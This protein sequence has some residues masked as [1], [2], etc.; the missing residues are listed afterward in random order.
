MEVPS[1]L[2]N[3]VRDGR[4]V[5]FLGAGASKDSATADG[6][7]CPTTAEL[8]RLLSDKFLG[9][10][11]RD[12]Q[13][14]QIAEYAMSECGDLGRI[15]QFIREIFLA[16]Q[17]TNG[18]RLV[19]RFV[20]RGLVTTNYDL[21]IEDT[22]AQ[23]K[24]RLQETRPMIENK[25]RVDDNL[26]DARNVLLLKLHGCITRITSEMCPLILTPDQ[27]LEHRSGRSRLF[28]TLQEWGAEH[29]LVFV[30]HS[31]QD[32]DI[33]AVLLELRQLWEFRPR[34]Y[35]VAP[36]GDEIKARFFETKKITLLRGTFEE[37]FATLDAAIGVPFRSLASIR[38]PAGG[39]QIE[40]HF[41]AG[42]RLSDSTM[43][44]MNV[45]VEYVNGISALAQMDPK[46]FYKGYTGG[47]APLEQE[48]DVRRGI[49]DDITFEY[50]IRDQHEKTHGP[51]V[52]LIKA[53]AGAGKS[54]ILHRLAWDA[55]REYECICLFSK[56]Q[57]TL[58]AA[59]LQELV[60]SLRRRIYLFVDDAAD[61]S[62]ELESL[63]KRLGPE[64]DYLTILM[65]ERINEW[66]I[67]GQDA[68]PFITDEY[69]LKYLNAAE[70]DA[71]LALLERHHALGAHLE[72]LTLEER[73]KE[74]SEHAG[75]QLLVAL[76]EA[77]LGIPFE[78]ILVD[79]FNKITPFEAQRLYQTVCVLNRLNVPVRAGLV[80]RV[81]GIPFE[82]FEKRFFAPLEHV[83][84]AQR[85]ETTQDYHY[86]ARHPHIADVVFLKVLKTVEERFDCYIR[87][88][89]ALNVS[90]SVDWKAF[91]QM[92]RAR[93][94][95]DLFP[96]LQMVKAVFTA[97]RETVG[98]DAH[99][100]HQMGIYEMNRPDG[101]LA[102]AS[103]ALH[104]AEVLA[105]HDPSIR[106]SIAELKLKAD[107]RSRTPLEK[108]KLLREAAEIS[109]SLIHGEKTDSYA[110][111][112]LV[113]VEIRELEDGL[114]AGAPEAEIEALVKD[115]ESR[116]FDAQQE[117]PG[118]SHLLDAESRLAE[119][120]KDNARA[121]NA[122]SKA[123]DANPRN[124]IIAVR[125]ARQLERSGSTE[126]AADILRKALDANTNDSRLH[127]TYARL[128]MATT[129]EDGD[130]I[131]YHLRRA[132]KDGDDSFEAQLLYGRQLFL[133]GN[134]DESRSLFRRL[135]A[136]RVAPEI[137]NRLLHPIRGRRFEGRMSRPQG[138]YAFI[139]R[140]GPS[141]QIYVHATNVPVDTWEVLTMGMR[142]RFSIAFSLC[143]VNAFDLETV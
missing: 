26:R 126:K 31:V 95:L 33:R 47:F 19:P 48:L 97:A 81:H 74:L 110:H 7:R 132:F 1:D 89:K 100:L 129:P 3:Q 114:A 18:H 43:Q 73:R 15:Q 70:I 17:P 118:D 92:V 28:N 59:P 35:V 57:G 16:L 55:A 143:G 108:S 120:L 91:W 125:L 103:R 101:D 87:C 42:A 56:S 138:S 63:L 14:S 136:I 51:E 133:N 130:N 65:A 8:G 122:L 30:G 94:L 41:R 85:D 40:R 123:F 117:F 34:Y 102:E 142:V 36:D 46:D 137:K 113:K 67:Q 6:R 44:F 53:H 20:W 64:G 38:P 72:G 93:N 111:H 50:L 127:Y 32:P 9:G 98:E 54:V 49:S 10:Y 80:A 141:D 112:T 29:P 115:A 83:V 135:S 124:A 5:L 105:R 71:L 109:A 86:R 24:E 75:R 68:A 116:L 96:D 140:D 88:L 119:I 37:F 66:N 82:Q 22:Y 106:H 45:D 76:H 99:L 139:T 78:S 90:Y 21:L 52:V 27:Y 62:R 39:H 79:E 77:T 58:S 11:L 61:R 134:F 128:L 131:A 69:E 23:V 84:F 13:L 104:R 2:V 121:T 107:D 4:V 60:R 12:G 25:D